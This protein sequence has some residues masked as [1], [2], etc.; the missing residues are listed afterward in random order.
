MIPWLTLAATVLIFN[1]TLSDRKAIY[2]YVLGGAFLFYFLVTVVDGLA[3]DYQ[4][5]HRFQRVDCTITDA[6]VKPIGFANFILYRP[7]LTA[8]FL[9]SK[10]SLQ[11]VVVPITIAD[12]AYLK[13][14]TAANALL[15]YPIQ[16][17]QTCWADPNQPN[18]LVLQRAWFTA[19]ESRILFLL[20]GM[21]LSIMLLVRVWRWVSLIVWR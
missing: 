11:M 19:L 3:N 10:D 20:S 17:E 21:L 16:S 18:R 2:L 6:R 4:V 15:S 13:Y 9:D 7:L 5:N 1:F 12:T 14:A 8:R